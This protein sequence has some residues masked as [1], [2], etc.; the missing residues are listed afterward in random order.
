MGF[1]EVNAVRTSFLASYK[2]KVK[3]LDVVQAVRIKQ[4][5]VV[6]AI[7]TR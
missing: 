6:G 1:V 5:L 4:D 2:D 3:W 7:R